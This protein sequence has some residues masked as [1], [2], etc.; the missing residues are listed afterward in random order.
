MEWNTRKE[1]SNG[2]RSLRN[3]PSHLQLL[4]TGDGGNVFYFNFHPWNDD[5][6]CDFIC[7]RGN[8]N[9]ASESKRSLSC[10]K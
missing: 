7:F 5:R 8:D 4:G 10:L 2:L 1:H 3:G 6:M 9:F